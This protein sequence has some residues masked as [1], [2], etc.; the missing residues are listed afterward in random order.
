MVWNGLGEGACY[1]PLEH[2]RYQVKP[3]LRPFGTD[4]GNGQA[5]QQVFQLDR[6]FAHYRQMKELARAEHFSWY[7]QTHQYSTEVAT[8]IAQLIIHRLIQEHP[9]IFQLHQ[10]SSNQITFHSHLT[11]ETLELDARYQLRQVYPVAS[12]Q[13][14]YGSALDALAMQ[15][16]EDLAVVS[17]VGDRH[18]V[19]AIHLCFP[20][21]WAAEEKI[22]RN[23]ATVHGPVAGMESMNRRGA[24][25]VH[26]MIT[27]RPAVR[28]AW[29]LST[30][31]HLN[32]H[33]KSP[34]GISGDRDSGRQFDP[35]NPCLFLRI[36]RQV[37]WGLPA[38]DAALFTI[39]TYFQDCQGLKQ[40][41][42]R[43]SQLMAAIQS[44][45]PESLTYKGLTN[46]REAILHWLE[47]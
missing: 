9:Q 10:A 4:F 16:Q 26:T 20:N 27:R 22:G 1:F 5:D 43:Q 38:V 18:W 3:G 12:M 25:L 44:M 17:R 15:V 7:Y 45:S 31:T 13:T 29:G 41:P 33:P 39:R 36:E 11:G 47:N 30:D 19:S 6:Q 14:P 46:S 42:E 28:F 32:H 37:V 21:H 2:G 24:A 23:F 35:D 34:P 40:K 8:A